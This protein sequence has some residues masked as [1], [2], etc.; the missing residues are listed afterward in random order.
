[1][2]PLQQTLPG[3]FFDG[4]HPVSQP[5]GVD[6]GLDEVAVTGDESTRR[7]EISALTVSPKAGRADRF[8]AFPDGSQCQCPDDPILD[9][10]SQEVASEGPVAWLESNVWAA[11]ASVAIIAVML[12]LGYVYGL[13]AVTE[14]LVKRVP[15]S[16]EMSLGSRMLETLG[17]SGWFDVTR[18]DPEKLRAIQIDFRTLCQDLPNA[19]HFRLVFHNS[20][21]MGPNAFALPG[22]IIIITDQMI[23]LAQTREEILAILAHEI[24]HIEHRHS[25]RTIVQSSLAALVATAVTADAASLSAAVAGA[26]V[27]LIQKK[28]SRQFEAAADEFAFNLLRDHNVSPAAFADIME[29]LDAREG[30]ARPGSFLSSH[31]AT[32]DR[33]R[34]ARAYGRR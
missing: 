29:R 23:E 31:P 2:N 27:I 3:R 33:M 18:I 1:M 7:W 10:L 14:S 28:Y 16:T 8:V 15:I 5:V 32:A 21:V 9:R 26:P 19:P 13:P 4:V 11:A 6:F 25:L 17:K 12:V 30:R 24:G 34:R 22:R 20:K